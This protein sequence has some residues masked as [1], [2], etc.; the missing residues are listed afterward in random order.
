MSE[1]RETIEQRLRVAEGDRE[2]AIEYGDDKFL[3]AAN[4]QIYECK[5]KLQQ[6]S[7]R[8]T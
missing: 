7:E 4:F 5:T 8:A 2:W 6:W 3:L 1:S